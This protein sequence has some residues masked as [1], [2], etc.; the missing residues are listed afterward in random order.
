MYKATF[1]DEHENTVF[2]KHSDTFNLVEFSKELVETPRATRYEVKCLLG[3]SS[4]E[5]TKNLG[6]VWEGAL[7]CQGSYTALKKVAAI[8]D[9]LTPPQSIWVEH[10]GKKWRYSGLEGLFISGLFEPVLDFPMTTNERA[11]VHIHNA[12][13]VLYRAT[14]PEDETSLEDLK[15]TFIR[16]VY[17]IEHLLMLNRRVL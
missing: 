2:E 5:L 16:L 15:K 10:E 13:M 8:V 12:L 14:N 17:S 7:L 9:S 1:L 6:Y 3:S 11:K 4:L